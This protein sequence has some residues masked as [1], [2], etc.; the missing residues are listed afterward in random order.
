MEEKNCF[1]KIEGVH[2]GQTPGIQEQFTKILK[3]FNRI[4][5]IGTHAG[6]LTLFLYRNKRDDCD[7]VS[8]DINHNFNQ[9]SKQIKIDFRIGDCFSHS[10]FNEIRELI[11][12]KSKR[13]LLLCDGGDKNNEFKTFSQFLKNNDV[14]MCHDYAE[15]IEDFNK[16]KEAI[17]WVSPPESSL[18]I[19]SESINKYGLL[20][21]HYDEFKLVLW[22]S[23][24]KGN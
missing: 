19:I 24:M 15:T 11:L 21:Y 23:F 12:D 17:G 5:E 22:G 4:I 7:L 6:G 1:F 9:V 16:I 18:D 14:I 3:D 8:Y 20:K 13:V 10:I 2:V